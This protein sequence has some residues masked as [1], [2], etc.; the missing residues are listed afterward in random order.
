[1]TIA[2]IVT[3]E[4]R[5]YVVTYDGL[6][7]TTGKERRRWQLAGDSRD[8]AEAIAANL[9]RGTCQVRAGACSAATV[10]G[11]VSE[12][13]MPKRV[14]HLRPSTAH[15]YRWMI[16]KYITEHLERL[17]SDLLTTGRMNGTGL[18][19]KPCTTSTSSCAPPSST[20][21][22][23]ISST[24]TWHSTPPHRAPQPAPGKGPSHGRSTSS[25][26]S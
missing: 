3:G 24:T 6:D 2:Y 26:P 1:M 10:G 25:E 23:S 20:P 17:Y 11:F 22:A 13:W 12:T 14:Q 21:C 18:A 15:R 4:N 16:D 9:T 5:F 8:D 19:P 7:P